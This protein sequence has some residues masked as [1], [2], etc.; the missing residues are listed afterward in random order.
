MKI[1]F[2]VIGAGN[3]G[4]RLL[5]NLFAENRLSEA[6]L[7]AYVDPNPDFEKLEAAKIW[8]T[9]G[10]YIVETGTLQ[11]VPPPTDKLPL[12]KAM[13]EWSAFAKPHFSEMVID[14][15]LMAQ[16]APSA[17]FDYAN[18][19]LKRFVLPKPFTF[20]L[21]ILDKVIQT[22]HQQKINAAVGSTWYYSNL[23]ASISSHL[24]KLRTQYPVISAQLD[25]LKLIPDPITLPTHDELPHAVQIV[26]ATGL[27]DATKDKPKVTRAEPLKVSVDYTPE[28]V[29]ETVTLNTYTDTLCATE[30][31]RIRKLK[32]Y[33]EDG[34]PEADIVADYDI[35]FND[36]GEYISGGSLW[37]D[38]PAYK[39]QEAFPEDTLSLMYTKIVKAIQKPWQAFQ[40]DRSILTLDR[41]R[42]IAEQVS[43]IHESWS[44]KIEDAN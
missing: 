18:Q 31:G 15:A 16:A 6:E 34:D 5:G 22:V 25:Y 14:I 2:T 37:I 42:P 8:S 27:I 1:P 32:I 30:S 29:A 23:T 39:L 44:K 19:G 24:E 20:E 7:V 9:P 4:A 11:Q 17:F 33:L 41:Y 38:T 21:S 10:I 40:A 35:K 13:N 3:Y 36:Q 28:N 12:F 26:A 43:K